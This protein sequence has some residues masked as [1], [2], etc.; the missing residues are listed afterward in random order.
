M[1]LGRRLG[2]VCG[3]GCT[4]PLKGVS[5][6]HIWTNQ[7]GWTDPTEEPVSPSRGAGSFISVSF[8]PRCFF[9][10][11]IRGET[12]EVT[13]YEAKLLCGHF[14]S[15]GAQHVGRLWL[16]NACWMS[17]PNKSNWMLGF[18][19]SASRCNHQSCKRRWFSQKIR[20][21][22]FTLCLLIGRWSRAAVMK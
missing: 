9:S 4:A 16:D 10:R 18:V 20:C 13:A 5:V 2:L 14:D 11:P 21:F 3:S 8:P 17:C 7:D 12:P 1:A 6:F 19:R 15:V 22:Y